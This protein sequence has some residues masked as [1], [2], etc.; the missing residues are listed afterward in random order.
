[1]TASATP[2]GGGAKLQSLCL[3]PPGRII[4]VALLIAAV[5][6]PAPALSQQVSASLPLSVP[7]DA[8]TDTPLAGRAPWGER[9]RRAVVLPTSGVGGS[10]KFIFY[11]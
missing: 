3:R 9:A 2:R 7:P 1:M 6:G 8:P 11:V 5:L 10:E 4:G